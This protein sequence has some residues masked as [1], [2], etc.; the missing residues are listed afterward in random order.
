MFRFHI[1]GL[2]K[3]AKTP[4]HGYALVS[5]YKRSS[6]HNVQAGNIYRELARLADES[7]VTVAR[8]SQDDDRRRAFYELTEKGRLAFE[9]WFGNPP[10]GTLATE[11]DLAAR[12]A[13]MDAVDRE[14]AEEV[15]HRWAIDLAETGKQILRSLRDAVEP[16]HV[17]SPVSRMVIRRRLRS[18]PSDLQFIGELAAAYGLDLGARTGQSEIRGAA[19]ALP[20]SGMRKRA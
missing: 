1:L 5:E 15:C 12:A 9:D 10:R 8:N 19:I 13:T 11:A 17:V 7:L 4:L 16:G 14:F 6:R 3:S 18:M 2:L 20:W